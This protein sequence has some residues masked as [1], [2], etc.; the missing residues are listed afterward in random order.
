MS[1]IILLMLL[2][3]GVGFT[4]ALFRHDPY[5]GRRR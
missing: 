5:K 2:A 1:M 4:Y 3:F